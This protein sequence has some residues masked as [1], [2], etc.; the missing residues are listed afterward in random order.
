MKEIVIAFD[1]DGTIY[2]STFSHEKEGTPNLD[3]LNLMRILHGMKNT[4]IIVWSGGGKDYAEQIVRKWGL[5]KWVHS[6]YGKH[7]Y[8]TSI[9]PTVD[10][11]FDDEHLFSMADKNLIVRFK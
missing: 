11:A 8:D 3:V 1:V 4:R 9:Y 5:G 7:E 10:I 2:G 6:C